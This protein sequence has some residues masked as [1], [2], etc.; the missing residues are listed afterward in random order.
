MGIITLM[1]ETHQ[2]LVYSIEIKHEL[3]HLCRSPLSSIT[4]DEAESHGHRFGSKIAVHYMGLLRLHIQGGS[5]VVIQEVP[6]G[7]RDDDPILLDVKF[8]IDTLNQCD[9][10]HIFTQSNSCT[11]RKS[12]DSEFLLF[13]DFPPEH[14][15][16][17]GG[18]CS[19]DC[20]LEV[21]SCCSPWA[22]SPRDF[23]FKI[24]TLTRKIY[25]NNTTL[26]SYKKKY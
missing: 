26:I 15:L 16:S 2:T 17:R 12:L 24:S 3:L 19:Q 13:S 5:I 21:L 25:S 23:A 11:R 22:F 7:G 1:I 18:R 9:I 8:L 20:V 6:R 4:A 14:C 10:E